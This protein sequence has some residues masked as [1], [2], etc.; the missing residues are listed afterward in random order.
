MSGEQEGHLMASMVLVIQELPLH[1][2][3][4]WHW[5]CSS[6]SYL[7]KGADATPAAGLKHFYGPIQLP[8]C[9]SWSPGISSMLLSLY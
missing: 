5:W 8:L 1:T 9:N 3:A 4:T 7:H 6:Y 2:L